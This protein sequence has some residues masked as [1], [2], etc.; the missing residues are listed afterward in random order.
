MP[1]E[2][3]I[4]FCMRCAWVSI[5]AWLPT[6]NWPWVIYQ[7]DPKSVK[8]IHLFSFFPL[9]FL[10]PLFL[11]LFLSTLFSFYILF[12]YPCSFLLFFQSLLSLYHSFFLFHPSFSYLSFLPSNFHFFALL[13]HTV[14]VFQSI[15]CNK[16]YFNLSLFSSLPFGQTSSQ[17][18]SISILAKSL[19]MTS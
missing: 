7:L 11:F 16:L 18:D 17:P 2:P 6:I 1:T 9:F 4:F 5:F 15:L 10:L 3:S 19:F 14:N 8:Y 12:F 13:S